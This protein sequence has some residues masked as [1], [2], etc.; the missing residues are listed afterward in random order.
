[1]TSRREGGELLRDIYHTTVVPDTQD[2]TVPHRDRQAHIPWSVGEH[3][4]GVC[5][6]LVCV[7]VSVSPCP[8]VTP[9]T[10]KKMLK[11]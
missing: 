9:S 4:E 10:A 5:I 6:M 8:R 7:Q 1:M 3:I 11:K 2:G